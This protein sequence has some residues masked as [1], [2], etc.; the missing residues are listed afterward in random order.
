[1]Y[2][3]LDPNTMDGLWDP[4]LESLSTQKLCLVVSEGQLNQPL[5]TAPLKN[6]TA[7]VL[8]DRMMSRAYVR[9]GCA[10]RLPLPAH[11]ALEIEGTTGCL[12][13][14]ITRSGDSSQLANDITFIAELLFHENKA[15][16]EL[17]VPFLVRGID[18]PTLS[19]EIDERAGVTRVFCKP[20]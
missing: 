10:K 8:V 4:L 11:F 18:S 9:V 1:M 16:T 3:P 13:E 15:M 19:C 6:A 20:A 17:V 14:L 5:I 12:K 2:I 7:R